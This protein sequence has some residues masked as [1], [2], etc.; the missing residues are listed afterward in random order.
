MRLRIA[1]LTLLGALVAASPAAAF[2][3]GN[4]IVN[5][6]AEAG[7]ASP[8]GNSAV[9]VPGWMIE[10]GFTIGMYGTVAGFPTAAQSATWNGGSNFF[11]GGTPA[12][13]DDTFA[14]QQ[15]DLTPQAAQIDAGNLSVTLSALLGGFGG[16]EDSATIT[17]A[18]TDP[19][20]SAGT[21]MVIGPVTDAERGGS[22]TLLPRTAC[23]QVPKGVRLGSVVVDMHRVAGTYDDGTADNISLS[24]SDSACSTGAALPPAVPPVVGKSGNAA[25]V[26]GTVMVKVPGSSKFVTLS[27]PSKLPVGSEVD[28]TKGVVSIQTA[29]NNSGGVQVGSFSKGTF[30]ITQTRGV[31]PLT[32]MRLSGKQ[33]TCKGNK[34]VGSARPR[35]LFGDTHKGHFLTRGRH[36]TATVRGTQWLTKDTCDSTTVTVKRGTVIVRDLTKRKNFSVKAGHS[37]TA[38]AKK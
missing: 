31:S 11:A 25:V 26:T 34:L 8:D 15:M 6:D 20:G 35:Q 18:L 27:D 16:Q 7:A 22:T 28:A 29:A 1:L 14:V 38:H 37:Y 32:E 12:S 4:L 9:D 17:A 36:A 30:V 3:S 23:V 24:L 2:S 13:G 10:N 19:S 21:G 33:P 5:G